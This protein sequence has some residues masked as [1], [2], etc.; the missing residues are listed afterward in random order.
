MRSGQSREA[1]PYTNSNCAS[2]NSLFLSDT[3]LSLSRS[4]RSLSGL[5][6]PKSAVQRLSP[7]IENLAKAIG[8]IINFKVCIA[9]LPSSCSY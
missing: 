1:A 5:G 9:L 7:C 4:L 3:A 2:Q 6:K 8:M